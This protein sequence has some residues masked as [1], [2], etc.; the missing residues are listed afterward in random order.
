MLLGGCWFILP[1]VKCPARMWYLLPWGVLFCRGNVLRHSWAATCWNRSRFK[2]S[3][4][5]DAEVVVWFSSLLAMLRA[6]SFLSY[7][8]D[9]IVGSLGSL[10]QWHSCHF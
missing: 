5:G 1:R 3:R 10:S 7:R 4:K 6:N 2:Q 9:T 8:E